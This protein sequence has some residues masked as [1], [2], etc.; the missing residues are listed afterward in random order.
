[1]EY[2]GFDYYDNTYDNE[3]TSIRFKKVW[4]MEIGGYFMAPKFICDD[5]EELLVSVKSVEFND[6]LSFISNRMSLKK[7]EFNLSSENIFQFI[8]S[9][10]NLQ[11]LEILKTYD[12]RIRLGK[13]I[14][15]L[16]PNFYS[17]WTIK[18]TSKHSTF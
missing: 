6:L 9:C 17:E 4:K 12:E 15:K 8:R 3:L 16:L 1:M 5:V 7:L 2:L 11:K 13:D 14:S 18:K 10:Q